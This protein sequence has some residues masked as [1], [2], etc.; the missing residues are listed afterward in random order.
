METVGAK[1]KA[2][3]EA[4]DMT[5]SQVAEY[6]RIKSQQIEGIE[7]ND[8]SSI[9]APMY[10]KGFIKLYAQT[11]EPEP[12]PLIALYEAQI[13]GEKPGK[14]KVRPS[15]RKNVVAPP[16]VEEA[17][18]PEPEAAEEVPPPNPRAPHLRPPGRVGPRPSLSPEPAPQADPG[19]S[20]LDRI[21]Q[22]V[23][24]VAGRLKQL[25]LPAVKPPK[26]DWLRDHWQWVAGAA[27]LLLLL[28]SLP[29]ACSRT[30]S[31]DLEGG[32]PLTNPNLVEPAPYRFTLD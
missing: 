28:F 7:R 26:T 1:L 18:L 23:A 32:L 11:V 27:V 12:E 14:P 6:T 30:S 3:R 20:V 2:A 19:V 29:R 9:P 22:G 25:R 16:E 10:V 31:R 15:S 17:P 8:F 21:G 24:G 5:V 4:Q 13:Q